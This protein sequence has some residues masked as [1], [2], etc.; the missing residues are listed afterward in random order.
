MLA[1]T[2]KIINIY[3]KSTSAFSNKNIKSLRILLVLLIFA[4]MIEFFSLAM[5]PIYISFLMSGEIKFLNFLDLSTYF[6][7]TISFVNVTFVILLIFII[8]FLFLVLINYYELY[9]IKK[10]K[11]EL[12]GKLLKNYIN[13]NYSFFLGNS[14]SF[15][16]NVLINEISNAVGFIQSTLTIF[17]EFLLFLCIFILVFLYE[18]FLSTIIIVCLIFLSLFFY[19]FT[20]SQLKSNSIQRSKFSAEVIKSINQ[21]LRFIKEIKVF[22]KEIFFFKTYLSN[23]SNFE[24]KILIQEFIMR[25]PKLIFEL[26]GLILIFT[27]L[28]IYLNRDDVNLMQIAPFIALLSTCVI[29]IMPSFKSISGSLTHLVSFYN[30]YQ[31]ILG[32]I[33]DKFDCSQNNSYLKNTKTKKTVDE[34]NFLE[35]ENLNYKYKKMKFTICNLN[36]KIKKNSITGIMGKSGSG[37]TTFINIILGLLQKDSGEIKL[38]KQYFSDLV[39][40]YVPQDILILDDSLRSNIAFGINQNYIDDEKIKKTIHLAGLDDFFKKNNYDLNLNLSEG[41]IRI[42]GGERQRIGIARAL[43]IDPDLIIF[44]ESTSA[45]DVE[46]EKEILVNI[47]NLSKLITIIM[48]AHKLST[49]KICELIY[50]I[51]KG[52]VKDFNTIINLTK[53]YNEINYLNEDT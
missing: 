18:P 17:K 45:L 34:N 42:S 27:V 31:L 51:E 46:T 23:K 33:L 21:S 1:L 29:K 5:I 8:K 12:S 49:L 28:L 7:F 25:L 24:E 10:I 36:I 39:I 43:Y 37:K 52:R 13:K 40:S 6:N 14:V 38:N 16:S 3:K 26:I 41:G 20:F 2:N 30:S 48:V 44:D 19:F 32:T 15:L 4:N 11:V 53:K 47:K 22:N 50:Y 35:I 9:V